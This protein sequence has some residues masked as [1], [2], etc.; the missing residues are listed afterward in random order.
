MLMYAAHFSF[1]C[2][3]YTSMQTAIIA[4]IVLGSSAYP[5]YIKSMS[6]GGVNPKGGWHTLQH[7]N[8]RST[9]VAWYHIWQTTLAF[10]AASDFAE[11]PSFLCTDLY[12]KYSRY[13][14]QKA[15]HPQP[16]NDACSAPSNSSLATEKK[17]QRM[18]R[19]RKG[20]Y[21]MVQ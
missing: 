6:V 13:H 16:T 15:V 8:F 11:I 18:D 10:P 19:G 17:G 12:L 14:W 2:T 4:N 7:G 9:A 1:T 3:R 5:V 20:R 21:T